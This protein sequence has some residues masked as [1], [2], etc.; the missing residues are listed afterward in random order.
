MRSAPK[1][2]SPRGFTLIEVLLAFTILSVALVAFYSTLT[3]S[4]VLSE[5]NRQIKIALLDAQSIVEEIQGMPFDL[6][7]DPDYPTYQAP[8]PRYRHL[9]EVDHKRLFGTDP[10]T[11][12]ACEPHLEDESIVVWYGSR[13]DVS[14][15]N[16][17]NDFFDAE[18]LDYNNTYDNHAN[19]QVPEEKYRP[20]NNDGN[21]FVTPEPLYV[22]VEVSWVGPG[23]VWEG[24]PKNRWSRMNQRITFVRSR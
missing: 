20:L 1:D 5:T 8:K 12:L 2:F 24:A 16:A 10:T 6:I 9:Q 23:K 17:N 7:M 11:G 22:T 13:L 18:P 3:R 14:D 21:Q 19:D 4:I 15:K